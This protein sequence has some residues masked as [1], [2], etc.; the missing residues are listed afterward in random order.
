MRLAADR[1]QADFF[2][3]CI[4][5]ESAKFF[6]NRLAILQ[7]QSRQFQALRY[8]GLYKCLNASPFKRNYLH[9]RKY[10]Y[11]FFNNIILLGL[12]HFHRLKYHSHVLQL[13]YNTQQK[14]L[15][16]DNTY[17]KIV[18]K[19]NTSKKEVL[20]GFTPKKEVMELKEMAF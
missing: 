11:N 6:Y 19:D 14:E 7:Q 3:Y 16:A 2:Q 5:K 15:L 8:E 4:A 13:N 12:S 9:W 20:T 18:S 17:K 10:T 1:L